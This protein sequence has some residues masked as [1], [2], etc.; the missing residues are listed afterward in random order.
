MK[1]LALHLRTGKVMLHEVPAPLVRK[2]CV[3]IRTRKSLVSAGT[4]KMLVSFGKAGLLSKAMREPGKFR[5]A[6]AKI[7]SEGITNA[8]SLISNQLS[9]LIPLGY[10]QA[11]E[12]IAVGAGVEGFCIGDRVVSNGC[13]AEVVCVPVNLVA[14]IPAN[15]SDEEAA[16]TVLAAVGLQSIRLL[17]PTLGETIVVMGLGLIGLLTAELLRINGC[18]VICIEPDQRRRELAAKRGFKVFDNSLADPESGLSALNEGHGADGII[19]ATAGK[20]GFI[21]S[22]AA[23]IARKR[24]RIVLVGTAGLDLERSEFYKK[25]LSFQVSCSYGPGRYDQM[26]EEE[27]ID[28][29][30]PYVRWTENRNFQAV[31][32]LLQEGRLEVKSLISATI[33]L[34]ETPAFYNQEEKGNVAT[35]INYPTRTTEGRQ[36]DLKTFKCKSSIPIIGI[37][38][39]G[40][41]VRM[42]LLPNLKGAAVKYIASA[43]GLNAYNL[44]RQYKIARP[45]SDYHQILDDPEIDLVIIATRHNQHGKL[46]IEA[47]EA[48]KQVFV[49]KPLTIYPEELDGIIEAQHNA[50]M[51]LS[52]GFNRR[53][54]PY[55]SKM[56][57]L[58][59]GAQMNVTVTVNAGSLPADSWLKDPAIGGGRILGE[60]CHFID[61]VTCLTQSRVTAVCSNAMRNQTGQADENV[62]ILLGYLNGSAGVVNYFS[63]GSSKYQKERV[64][65]FSGGCTLVLDDFKFLV[66][67]GF[68]NFNKL[69]VGKDKG[70]KRQ[71][72]QFS[73]DKKNINLAEISIAE[74]VNTTRA[75]FAAVESLKTGHWIEVR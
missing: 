48:G 2:G 14:R 20:S 73:Q 24:G 64:E 43:G 61:L 40:N 60:A 30:F 10:A 28:Y 11:G 17:A 47:L 3:L 41:F 75:T 33:A 6:L 59:A 32:Q 58:L 15:V 19:I 63:N 18:Q 72:S 45:V 38:G 71:F 62:S 52:I 26:Y 23:R 44:A 68:K 34:Q 4:E 74:V 22:E 46:V 56:R 9:Q 70:H 67:Y 55:V 7:K 69:S 27:G 42:T 1:Q 36:G 31:L 37:I 13:H 54:S 29:P 16:F 39:A 57:E 8:I 49:E 5:L 65:V 21:I 53:Y 25:E 35:L 66:G 50:R 51:Q 12:V